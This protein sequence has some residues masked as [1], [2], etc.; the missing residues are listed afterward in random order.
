MQMTDSLRKF[1]RDHAADDVSTLVLKASRYKSIDLPFAVKQIAARRR[2]KDKLP[3]W[4]V[5]DRLIFPSVLAAEQCS[6]EQTALYKQRLVDSE[7]VIFDLTGGLGVDSY[8]LS[9]KA[10]TVVYV[11]R[12]AEYCET[13]VYNMKQLEAHNVHVLNSDAVD[14][15]VGNTALTAKEK[16]TLADVEQANV[17]Y[18]DP[19]RRGAGDRRLFAMKDCEPDLTKIWPLLREKH[20]KIIVKLSPMLDISRV[21]LQL[22]E[23]TAVHIV[24]VK[25]DCKELLAVAGDRDSSNEMKLHDALILPATLSE[26]NDDTGKSDVKIYCVN[27][28]SSGEEQSFDFGYDEEKTAVVS[29]AEATGRY[30]YEPNAS[31]LKAGA[32]KTISSRYGLKKLHV[33]SHLYTSDTCTPFFAGRIFEVKNVYKFDNRLCRELSARIPQANLS[34]RNFPLSVDEL[35][36]RTR[37]TDGGD[38][39]LFAT[40][41]ADRNKVLIDCRKMDAMM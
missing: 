23:V 8:F 18:I 28:T 35:R 5:N 6:S 29:Y 24:S 1:I 20:A 14:L 41:L 32:Y 31:I 17:F 3:L 25:N 21:L 11:E 16:P 2:V 33:N 4:A 26:G 7:D 38:V 15:F 10:R 39:Y 13:A 27:F 9:R 19:A 36:K 12:D 34:V 30:L 37:I 22:P 40:T